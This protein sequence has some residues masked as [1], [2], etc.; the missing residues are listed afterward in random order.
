MGVDMP[1][2]VD[3]LLPVIVLART[4]DSLRHRVRTPVTDYPNLAAPSL[5]PVLKPSPPT[6]VIEGQGINVL[7]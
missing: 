6:A 4:F 2:S 5:S 3:Y 7:G 1:P